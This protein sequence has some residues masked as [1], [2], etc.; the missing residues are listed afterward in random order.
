MLHPMH[1]RSS[2]LHLS[3]CLMLFSTFNVQRAHLTVTQCPSESYLDRDSTPNPRFS[4]CSEA[5]ECRGQ[6]LRWWETHCP[7]RTRPKKECP[8]PFGVKRSR[9][10]QPSQAF[11]SQEAGHWTKLWRL[12]WVACRLQSSQPGARRHWVQWQRTLPSTHQPPPIIVNPRQAYPP[13]LRR[14][15]PQRPETHTRTSKMVTAEM[16]VGHPVMATEKDTPGLLPNIKASPITASLEQDPASR[17]QGTAILPTL[18][19]AVQ[20]SAAAAADAQTTGQGLNGTGMSQR[21][22]FFECF[23]LT[24][25]FPPATGQPTLVFPLAP[26]PFVVGIPSRRTSSTGVW[27]PLEHTRDPFPSP[28]NAPEAGSCW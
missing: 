8:S 26:F 12:D 25:T 18:A 21:R 19:A 1:P 3:G 2:T 17:Q 24:V 13:L 28:A 22:L 11:S 14:S 27:S 16:R 20:M 7:V 15:Q 23:F 9:P 6:P 10:G 5:A 4:R